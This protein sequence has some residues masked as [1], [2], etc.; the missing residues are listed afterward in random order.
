[1]ASDG[2]QALEIAEQHAGSIDLLFADNNMPALSGVALARAITAKRPATKVILTSAY[3]RDN[4]VMDR[5][6]H[7]IAKPY[8][9]NQLLDTVREALQ[10]EPEGHDAK[11]SS[12]MTPYRISAAVRTASKQ[13]TVIIEGPGVEAGGLRLGFSSRQ[14]SQD[15]VD[16]MNLAFKQGFREG[17][18]AH[19]TAAA[20]SSI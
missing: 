10:S 18:K 1:M 6:W 17:A 7:F 15:L 3:L 16:A 2:Q 8:L 9:P 19:K 12:V 11:G 14:E 13:I 4:W 5:R 20:G